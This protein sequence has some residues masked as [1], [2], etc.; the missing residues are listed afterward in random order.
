MVVVPALL[1]TRSALEEQIDRLETHYLA[2]PEGELY[3]ALLS[4][5]TDSATESAGED[6]ALLAMAAEGIA[7]LNRLHGNGA[8]GARFIL[9]HRRRVWSEVQ[10]QWMG[11]ERKRGKLHELNGLLRGATDYEFH[12]S[13]ERRPARAVGRPLR[14]HAGCRYEA[15]ARHRAAPGGQDGPPAESSALRC[16]NRRRRRGLRRPAAA[17]NAVLAS[18]SRGLD[19]SARVLE[20]ERDRSVYGRRLGCLPGSVRRRLLRRQGHLRCGRIR[21]GARRSR[22]RWTHCSVTISSKAS[23]RAPDWLPTSRS[24][25][26]FPSR[27]DVAAARQHR[28]ARG[29]WQL[30]PWILGGATQRP[31]P[32]DI[33]ACRSSACGKWSTICDAR[34]RRLRAVAALLVGWTVAPRRCARLDGLCR[35]DDC[36]PALLPIF[37]AI[38][39]RR[40]GVNA[41]QPSACAA[42]GYRGSR[43][44]RPPPDHFSCASGL[45]D[46]R[47]DQ[48]NAISS[49]HQPAQPAAVGYCGAD[50][51]QVGASISE[52]RIAA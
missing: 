17:G 41:A 37:A 25:R 34:C 5:W 47:R 51:P 44:H 35:A 52:A 46:E 1:T 36:L 26:S 42:K 14:H 21:S 33:A 50:E 7:R 49:V 29:D 9:L 10:T 43:P 20:R 19:L 31:T 8:A 28:W 11:W 24:S 32:G 15:A 39:P 6:Q 3:F 2:S 30:L 22:I 48:S 18:R 45:A 40:A 23:L 4:D 16:A 13:G 38:V 12:V 27:Y